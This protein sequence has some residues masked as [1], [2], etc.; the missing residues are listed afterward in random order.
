MWALSRVLSTL[1]L[2]CA[3]FPSPQCALAAAEVV[4]NQKDLEVKELKNQMQMMMQENKGH[5]ISLK[6][7]QKVNRLQVEFFNV[8][9]SV[10]FIGIVHD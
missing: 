9:C 10:Y 2:S 5:V 7:A 6:E 4:F 8:P 3:F 1:N